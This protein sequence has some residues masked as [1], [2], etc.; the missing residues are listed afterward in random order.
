MQNLISNVKLTQCTTLTD[1]A[2]N[3]TDIKGSAIDMSNFETCLFVVPFGTITT[4]AAT[5]IKIQQSATTTDGDF[6]DLEGTSIT[7]ADDKDNKTFY[8]EVSKPQKRYVRLYVDRGTQNAVV[9]TITAIQSGA[10]VKPTTQD[11]TISTGELHVS[12]DEGTA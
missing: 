8:A 3:T 1:G 5:S 6:A 2:A 10:R 4:G 12:P 11:T 9:G 7:I